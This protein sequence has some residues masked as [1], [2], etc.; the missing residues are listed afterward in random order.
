MR[1]LALFLF[2]VATVG[3]GH[4]Q[5]N[6]V[7]SSFQASGFLTIATHRHWLPIDREKVRPLS[8]KPLN[9]KQQWTA[10]S[11]SRLADNTSLLSIVL[12]E[13]GQ[14]IYE[15]YN[16]PSAEHKHMFSWSMSKS[17]TAYTVG[18]ALCNGKINSIDRVSKE[19]SP[20]LRGSAQGDA[21]VKHLLMMAS[22][23]A[24]GGHGNGEHNNHA[25]QSIAIGQ[26]KS[27]H[28]YVKEHGVQ[29]QGFFGP[30]QPGKKFIYT[31]LDTL[32]LESVVEARGGFIREFEQNI[33]SKVG[34]ERR[35]SWVLDRDKRALTYSGFSAIPRDWARIAMWSIDQLK[36]SDACMREY[37]QAATNPQI[38]NH[39]EIGKN[40]KQYG[41]QT[42]IGRF[43]PRPSYWWVGYGGQRV[44][45]DPVTERIIVVSSWREDYMDQIYN[46]FGAWQRNY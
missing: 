11:A 32:A 37:M 20:E 3:Q 28:E 22:G 38:A 24:D 45:I 34:A 40:F 25:W 29:S 8:V 16:W 6:T 26:V 1:K 35:G 46:L 23:A 10:D 36:G 39:S 5:Q 27:G 30:S 33:W 42:W 18:S 9:E 43:G 14:L 21:S 13:R 19:L 17:L 12:I 2:A 31:N 41:Y 15:K 4:A 7:T 44:G